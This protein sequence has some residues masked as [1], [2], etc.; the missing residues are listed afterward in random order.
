MGL[1]IGPKI[2]LIIPKA[3]LKN[4]K[5]KSAVLRGIFDT[6][7]CIYLEHKN[8][9]LYP[10]M[11]IQ[12]ICKKL[13]EQVK[14]LFIELE[15]RATMY[16]NNIKQKGNRKP[17]YA[18]VIRGNENFHKFMKIIMPANQKH[19]QKYEFYRKSFK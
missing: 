4:D 7:G 18:I 5:L 14:N 8:H 19:I 12:T 2:D 11:E 10:R 16:G 13:A 17:L 1:K 9:K 6:D 15:L 3:F